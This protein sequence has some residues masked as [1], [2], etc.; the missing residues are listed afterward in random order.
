MITEQ[1]LQNLEDTDEYDLR[2]HMS[3][4]ANLVYDVRE[5]VRLLDEA[6]V[7]QLE[8]EWAKPIQDLVRGV[9]S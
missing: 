6:G 5:L 1:Q 4:V 3:D 9:D 2:H 7:L 8:D